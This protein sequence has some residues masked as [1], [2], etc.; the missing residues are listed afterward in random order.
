MESPL[1]NISATIFVLLDKRFIGVIPRECHPE[2]RPIW[3][4][5]WQVMVPP[6]YPTARRH[7]NGLIGPHGGPKVDK[8]KVCQVT[9]SVESP[10]CRLY[11]SSG[12]KR[13]SL[14]YRVYKRCP[15]V[16]RLLWQ[17][18]CELWERNEISDAWRQAEGLFIP[19]EEGSSTVNKFR[20]YVIT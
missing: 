5:F 3:D 18:L 4:S 12:S 17:N 10:S 13:S 2:K 9:G 1:S 11:I 19:I 20:N 16:A 14:P 15:K 6:V 7:R 8:Q